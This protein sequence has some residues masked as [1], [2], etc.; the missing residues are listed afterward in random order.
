MERDRS[1]VCSS[2]PS[3]IY[4][5]IFSGNCDMVI[6]GRNVGDSL[7]AQFIYTGNGFYLQLNDLMRFSDLIDIIRRRFRFSS[8]DVFHL[9]YSSPGCP[10]IYLD[11]DLDFKMLFC[12]AKIYKLDHVDVNVVKD[13]GSSCSSKSVLF[14]ESFSEI[15]DENDYLDDGFKDGPTKSYL[16]D[17]WGSYLLHKGQKFES[18]QDFRD[19]LRKYAVQTGFCYVLPRND[20]LYVRAVCENHGTEKCGWEVIG[21]VAPINNCFYIKEFN[22]IHTC[23][24]VLRNQTHR[25]LGSKIVRT[26]IESNVFLNLGLKPA[27]IMSNFKSTYG[28]EIS[29]KVASRAKK[30]C[31][32]KM[33]GSESDSFSLLSWY[34]D[35]VLETNPGSSFVL[36]VEEN[37]NRFQR[38]FVSYGGQVEGFKFSLPVLYVDG[39]FGKSIYKGQILSATGRNG[40]KGFFPLALC[41]CDS[42]TE[43][44]W[45]FFLQA[46]EGFAGTAGK[47]NHLYQNKRNVVVLAQVLQ[48]FFKVAYASTERSYYHHLQALRD[49]G[50]AE[51]IDEF[52]AEIPLENW[53]C[54]FF[55]GCRYG[56]M[57][58]SI[59]ESFN[60]W[61]VAER[62]MPPLA[63]IDQT[64]MKEMKMMSERRV[65]SKSWT[66]QLT[67]EMEKKLVERMHKACSFRVIASHESVYEVRDDEYS[68]SVNLSTHTCSCV[69]WQIN[70]FPCPHALSAIQ[71]ARLNVYDFIDL[72]FSAEY[73]RMS[74][75][76]PIH[77][78]SNVDSCTEESILPPITKRPAGRPK[79]KRIKSS[80]EKKPIRC[81]RCLKLEHHNRQSCTEPLN[82]QQ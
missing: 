7:I 71:A 27:D 67:P 78:V 46:P 29:Y 21:S 18:V 12:C 55:K 72:Y 43:D 75:S 4:F 13:V 66:T 36:E 38:V 44:N 48:K 42:E 17:D 33:Y 64:R 80:G 34:K 51:V 31:L 2:L 73:F 47:G 26:C 76:F 57:A 15:I 45:F 25:Q 24:G 77:P 52:I 79:A 3:R 62:S 10:V 11:S 56:I 32:E 65:E 82:G 81:G 41:I 68:Y 28:F 20:S 39:T 37:T 70:C 53:C 19:K 5:G 9:Q 30:R 14:D 49:E 59:A 54:A 8:S 22:N 23:K 1:L 6:G 50:G 58:N 60:K 40:D 16:S 61:I 63:M 74:Y 35:A 69:K